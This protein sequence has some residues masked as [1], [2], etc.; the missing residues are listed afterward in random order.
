MLKAPAVRAAFEQVTYN[1]VGDAPQ[2]TILL[3]VAWS[4]EIVIMDGLCPRV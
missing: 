2:Q 1:V 3:S 4:I